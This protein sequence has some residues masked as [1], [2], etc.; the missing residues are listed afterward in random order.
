M[1]PSRGMERTKIQTVQ[2]VSLVQSRVH[3]YELL[4]RSVITTTAEQTCVP[5]SVPDNSQDCPQL[6]QVYIAS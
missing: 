2:D 3:N 4:T 1:L 6:S 5:R